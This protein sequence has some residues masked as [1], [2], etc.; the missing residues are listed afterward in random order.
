MA[1]AGGVH[2]GVLDGGGWE[3]YTGEVERLGKEG[4]WLGI[5]GTSRIYTPSTLTLLTY[6][7]VLHS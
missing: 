4:G 5:N 3:G 1:V 2:W 6:W 7:D